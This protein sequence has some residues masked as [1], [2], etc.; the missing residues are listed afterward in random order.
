[1]LTTVSCM[2][3]ERDAHLMLVTR[4]AVPVASHWVPKCQ[5]DTPDHHSLPL[6]LQ[7]LQIIGFGSSQLGI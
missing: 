3:A 2:D 5:W 1:V 7:P 4:A 6:A